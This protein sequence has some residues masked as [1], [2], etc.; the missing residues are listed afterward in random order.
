MFLKGLF[1][2]VSM[3]II[4]IIGLEYFHKWTNRKKNK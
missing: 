4:C 1:V 3:T 2:L